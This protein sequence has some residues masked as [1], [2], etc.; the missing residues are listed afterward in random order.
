MRMIFCLIAVLLIP[1]HLFAA[2]F[3]RTLALGMRGEDVRALQE[4]LNTDRETHITETGAG[5]PGNETDYFGFATK[6]ALIKFQEKYR[7]D[8]LA[9]LN[10]TQGTGVFGA[11]TRGKVAAMTTTRKTVAPLTISATSSTRMVPLTSD[12]TIPAVTNPNSINL[13]YAITEVRKVGKS[14]GVSDAELDTVEASIRTVAATSTDLTKQF[15]ETA[16][17][18]SQRADL[19]IRNHRFAIDTNN[20]FGKVLVKLGVV[21]VAHAAIPL[22]FGGT[23]ALAVPCTCSPGVVWLLTMKPLP[24]TYATVLSYVSGTQLFASYV[25]TP[26]PAQSFLGLYSAGTQACYMTATPCVPA[27]NW[28]MITPDVGSSL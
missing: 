8:V 11:R 3:T 5:S 7:A 27:P 18:S 6:R 28:G 24:P 2:E 21:K 22:P 23:I 4:F 13:E 26:H 25:P 10:L 20:L 14:Q 19:N 1:T 9:P 17:I 12:N 15:I 16:T